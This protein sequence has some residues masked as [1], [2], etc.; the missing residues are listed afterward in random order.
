MVK[1]KYYADFNQNK[2]KKCILHEKSF[3][4]IQFFKDDGGLEDFKQS[5]DKKSLFDNEQ[6]ALMRLEYLDKIYNKTFL[7]KPFLN[8]DKL[9]PHLNELIQ[10]EREI[11]HRLDGFP[12]FAGIDF[13]DVSASG[14]QIRGFHVQVKGYSY[15]NQITI[16]Y[17]FS[18]YLE[19]IDNFV[20]MWKEHDKPEKVRGYQSFIADGEKYGWD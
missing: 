14:I 9:A 16:K 11:T 20:E 18:N 1:I 17:D 13:C 10:I 2:T 8:E 6:D 3:P 15:G 7:R 4:M 5:F 19:C 12:N